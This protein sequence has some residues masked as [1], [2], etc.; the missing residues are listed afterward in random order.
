MAQHKKRVAKNKGGKKIIQLSM[1]PWIWRQAK[2]AA[3]L[4]IPSI[5]P[6][7]LVAEAIVKYLGLSPEKE[8]KRVA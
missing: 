2:V 4:R 6:G 7:E 5:P 1:P 8:V 3:A